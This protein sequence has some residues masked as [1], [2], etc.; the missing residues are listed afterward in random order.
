MFQSMDN[1]S[2]DYQLGTQFASTRALVEIP[3]FKGQFFANKFENS[4][5]SPDNSL[6]LHI[7]PTMTAH[8]WNPSPV[9]RRYQDLPPADRSAFGAYA[10][11][12]LTDNKN[13]QSNIV[14][15]ETTAT[16]YRIYVSNPKFSLRV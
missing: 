2:H 16:S 3:L 5:P 14:N 13:N 12:I 7:D 10:K 15:F 8:T 4:Y 1:V 6:K 9:G 11:S